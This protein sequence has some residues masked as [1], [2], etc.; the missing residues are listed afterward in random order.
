[1][2]DMSSWVVVGYRLGF[3]AATI[4]AMVTQF[5]AGVDVVNFFS[6]FTIESNLLAVIVF[7]V[8]ALGRRVS[9]GVRGATVTYMSITGVVYAT[10]LSDQPA[11]ADST[12]RWV[13][14]V[15][16]TIMPIVVF[17]D[18]LLVPPAR[19]MR[20]GRALVWLLYPI[21]YGTYSLIRGAIVHWYPYP[22]INADLHTAGR[23]ALN[24]VG[25]VVG[26]TAFIWVI[27]VVGNLMRPDRH[28]T[29][30][31]AKQFTL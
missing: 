3:A 22:F 21:A 10:L 14:L 7:V 2:G 9:D 11:G 29:R 18:W 15:V 30:A 20:F 19:R 28:I 23:I 6:F 16:H 1:M 31:H 4:A 12:I 26:A 8:G 25:I 5:V 27:V 13:N 17:L 24:C